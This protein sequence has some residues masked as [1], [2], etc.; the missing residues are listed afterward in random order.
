MNQVS[1]L[2][3]YDKRLKRYTVDIIEDGENETLV[4]DDCNKASAFVKQCYADGYE[5]LKIY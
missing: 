5:Q 1:P 2:V 4:F 3:E